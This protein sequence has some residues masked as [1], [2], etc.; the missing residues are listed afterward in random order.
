MTEDEY[1]MVSELT[2]LRT[3]LLML[4]DVNSDNGNWL[5]VHRARSLIR[6]SIVALDGWIGAL[7]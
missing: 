7:D 4:D 3:A 2:K 1:V 6:E 5:R